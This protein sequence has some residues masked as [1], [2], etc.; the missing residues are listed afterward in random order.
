MCKIPLSNLNTY[1]G[2]KLK[3][4]DIG[5]QYDPWFQIQNDKDSLEG[6]PNC[7]QESNKVTRLF[8]LDN[9]QFS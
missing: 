9:P 5:P 6:L 8:S 2:C 1:I 7:K 3:Q 4:V